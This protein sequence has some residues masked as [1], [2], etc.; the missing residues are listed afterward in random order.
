MCF[1][2][3]TSLVLPQARG[4]T[5][6]ACNVRDLLGGRFIQIPEESVAVAIHFPHHGLYPQVYLLLFSIPKCGECRRLL[7][8]THHLYAYYCLAYIVSGWKHQSRIMFSLMQQPLEK[9]LRDSR[10]NAWMFFVGSCLCRKLGW[11]LS[12]PCLGWVNP[13]T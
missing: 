12:W 4:C 5:T 11:W 13:N 10:P 2:R 9:H 8:L 7:S 1:P 3:R 6:P